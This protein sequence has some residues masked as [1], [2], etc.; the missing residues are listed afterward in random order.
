MHL[1]SQVKAQS[2]YEFTPEERDAN[3]KIILQAKAINPTHEAV[4]MLEADTLS[5]SSE[6][7]IDDAIAIVDK[8]ISQSDKDDSI[9]LVIKANILTQKAFMELGMAQQ[10]Q[11]KVYALLAQSTFKSVE[12]LYEQAIAVEPDAAVEAMT[13]HAHFKTMIGEDIV[14]SEKLVRKALSVARSKDE[15]Q[16]LSQL[17][18]LTSAQLAAIEELNSHATSS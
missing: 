4:M 6:A 16:E 2:G 7:K 14:G 17:L 9:P 10:T 11:Q 12:E 13:Q 18:V 15:A 5:T 3:L 8:L 1:P